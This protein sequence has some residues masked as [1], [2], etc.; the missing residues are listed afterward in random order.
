[1]SK[2]Y[3]CGHCGSPM[4]QPIDV[5]WELTRHQGFGSVI[6]RFIEQHAA[7]GASTLKGRLLICPACRC[8]FVDIPNGERAG[9]HPSALPGKK[10]QHLPPNVQDCYEEARSCMGS[11]L[12]TAAALM[13]RKLIMNSAT[14]AGA[15]EGL[16]FA[17]YLQW[18]QDSDHITP[19]MRQYYDS[20]RDTGN[21][22]THKVVPIGQERA[23]I[24]FEFAQ[25]LIEIMFESPAKFGT[26]QGLKTKP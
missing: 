21:D 10:F 16:K 17:E 25:Q 14:E 4:E 24:A 6:E 9:V 5:L 7:I 1:M 3:T 2:K 11:G 12:H 23:S 18:L 19:A 8:P 26:A 22:A 15:K 20:V 13:C